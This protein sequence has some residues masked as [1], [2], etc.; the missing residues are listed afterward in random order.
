MATPA[1]PTRLVATAISQTEVDLAWSS[2]GANTTHY[3]ITRGP[4][5]GPYVQ[6]MVVP[7]R[8]TAYADTGLTAGTEYCYQVRAVNGTDESPYTAEACATTA[9]NPTTGQFRRW[10]GTAE[11]WSSLILTAAS[12]YNFT[13]PATGTAALLGIANTFVTGQAIS[14]AAGTVRSLFFQT[15]GVDRWEVRCNATAEGGG[16]AGSDLLIIADTDAGATLTS[17]MTATRSTGAVNF[18]AG[19]ISSGAPTG[20]AKGTGTGNFAG[21][22]YKNNTAY[23]NPDYAL[24]QWVTGKIERFAGNEGATDYRRMTLGEIESHIKEHLRL[25]RMSDESSGIFERADMVLEKLEELYTHIIE[26]SHRLNRLEEK[27]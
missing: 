20:G 14:G 27:P 21:D 15:V 3:Q 2:S 25:P 26:L 6:I 1:T 12:N 10:N 8:Q 13:V 17:V 4:T 18:P 16:N 9:A 24:E 11:A 7:V 22:I 5:G 23:T 19:G